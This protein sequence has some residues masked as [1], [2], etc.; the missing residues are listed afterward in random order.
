MSFQGLDHQAERGMSPIYEEDSDGGGGEKSEKGNAGYQKTD[1]NKR[2]RKAAAAAKAAARD[3]ADGE[4]KIT[5]KCTGPC[6]KTKILDE[7]HQDQAKCRECSG[8]LRQ[9]WRQA[10]KEDSVAEIEKM[11]SADQMAMMREF[12]KER[13]K[14]AQVSKRVKFN[15]MSFTKSMQSRQG[16]RS[17]NLKEMMW[18]GQWFEEAA[19]AAHGYLTREEAD[20]K[21]KEWEKD[22][23]IKKDNLGPKGFQR[24]AVPV[25]TLL[26][27][28]NELASQKELRQ[29]ERIGSKATAEAIGARARMVLSS[30][31]PEAGQVAASSSFG[32]VNLADMR[33]KAKETGVDFE[34]MSTPSLA[35]YEEVAKK[36]TRR[37]SGAKSKASKGSGD[38]REAASSDQEDEKEEEKEKGEESPSKNAAG[39]KWFDRETKCRKAERT[40]TESV[41]NLEKAMK[42]TLQETQDIMDEFRNHLAIGDANPYEAELAILE[43]RRNWLQAVFDGQNSLQKLLAEFDQEDS[44][45]GQEDGKTT[46][47]DVAALGRAGPCRGFRELEGLNFLRK[48]GEE[49]RTCATADEIKDKADIGAQRR[50]MMQTLLQAVKAA[51]TDLTGAKK[52]VESNAKKEAEKAKKVEAARA[53]EAATKAASGSGTER[54]RAASK[55]VPHGGLLM[56]SSKS[57]WSGDCGITVCQGQGDRSALDVCAPCLITGVGIPA[58]LG[59]RMAEFGTVFAKSALRTTEGRAQIQWKQEET[60][61][62]VQCVQDSALIPE[63]WRMELTSSELEGLCE[64]GAAAQLLKLMRPCAFGIAASAMQVGRTELTLLPCFRW[65]QTGT[66]MVA[67]WAPPQ[68]VAAGAVSAA[69]RVLAEGNEAQLA[70]AA[71]A[72]HLKTATVGPGNLLYVPPGAVLG[73]RVHGADLLGI[74]FGVLHPGMRKILGQLQALDNI[75]GQV[76][77]TLKAAQA[78]CSLQPKALANDASG[79]PPQDLVETGNTRAAARQEAVETVAGGGGEACV[80]LRIK[81]LRLARL[82]R[83]R[84]LED[85]KLRRKRN[86]KPQDYDR[87]R[88]R[89]KRKPLQSERPRRKRKRKPL[90]SERPRRKRQRKP[91]ESDSLRRKRRRKLQKSERLRRL[92]RKRN[93]KPQRSVRLRR[94]RK[95]KPQK[96]ARLRRRKPLPPKRSAKRRKRKRRAS[97]RR[98]RKKLQAPSVPLGNC[99]LPRRRKS[100]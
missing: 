28:F 70:N 37:S 63:Q 99:A 46:S 97:Q 91:Q 54:A 69:Q 6:A 74:R 11:S 58:E 23:T 89:R 40:F 49:F 34:A 35:Y 22:S 21:W 71:Q 95:R 1:K 88:R 27:E 33:A 57:W 100:S 30:D 83:R 42:Q 82:K 36:K 86:R 50:K 65:V 84:R 18:K 38:D 56:D 17:E 52:R 85:K 43:K 67:V 64:E 7:F 62:L 59:Q 92:R 76:A 60:P 15:F 31:D 45:Q 26:A 5:K 9:F 72:G 94:K 51:K 41:D 2:K 29:E 14:C 8:A 68:D 53:K 61:Q 20:A 79:S 90:K 80:R 39:K 96:S 81:L 93:R 48:F 87:L 78:A 3:G 75:P 25:K 32:D 73:Q 44:G 77:N 13:Q 66:M 19:K 55:K 16:D 12:M 98:R 47:H 24:L 4:V 10:K